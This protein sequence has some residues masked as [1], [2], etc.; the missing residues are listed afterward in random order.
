MK[1]IAKVNVADRSPQP[2]GGDCR[3]LNLTIEIDT[4]RPVDTAARAVL[5]ARRRTFVLSAM[6]SGAH[7]AVT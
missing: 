2:A 6:A 5:R 7:V 3:A 1:M 4:D